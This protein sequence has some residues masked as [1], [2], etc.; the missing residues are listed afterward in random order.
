MHTYFVYLFVKQIHLNGSEWERAEREEKRMEYNYWMTRCIPVNG[1]TS[2]NFE[3]FILGD[4]IVAA[5]IAATTAAYDDVNAAI[6]IICCQSSFL[7]YIDKFEKYFTQ[8]R[9]LH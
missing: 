8:A 5:S 3:Y 2:I 4:C 1:T 9:K 7:V 6:A